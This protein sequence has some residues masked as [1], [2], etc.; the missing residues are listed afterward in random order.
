MTKQLK[1]FRFGGKLQR[2]VLSNCGF[3]VEPGVLIPGLDISEHENQQGV[4]GYDIAG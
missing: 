2:V 3:M 4:A 1:Y